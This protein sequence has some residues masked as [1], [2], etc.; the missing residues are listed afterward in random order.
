MTSAT[1]PATLSDAARRLA[2][3]LAATAVAVV[4]ARLIAA[5]F[6]AVSALVVAVLLGAIVTNTVGVPDRLRPGTTFAAKQL[7]RLGIVVLGIRLS[8]GD[9]ADLGARGLLVVVA[10]VTLTF[11]GT[12]WLGRRLGVSPDLSLLVATGYSICGASAVAAMEPNTDASEEEVA[13]AIGLVTLFGT[14]SI[15]VLPLLGRAADMGDASFGSWV[16]A[17]THDVAQVVAAASTRSETAVAAAVVVKLTRVVLLAPL[18]A[19]VSLH[20]RARAAAAGVATADLPPLLP[21]FVIGFLAAVALRTTGWLPDEFISGAKTVE[22]VLLAAA[23]FGLGTGVQIDR[24]RTLGVRPLQLGLV[25]WV[26]VAGV[27]WL[28]V[29]VVL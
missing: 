2:P 21:A 25:S 15:V 8:L 17:A 10:T 18:V 3:G 14:V 26:L 1:S 5:Q 23:M 12:I 4:V 20:R 11:F 24:L 22:G 13:A 16:G 29:T 9:V 19:G 28:G 27:S 6:D 7:L